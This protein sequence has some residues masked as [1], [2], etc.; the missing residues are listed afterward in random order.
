MGLSSS[1]FTCFA[2][3]EIVK[4]DKSNK[5]IIFRNMFNYDTKIRLITI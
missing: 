2:V 4:T 1:T 5:G 3:H